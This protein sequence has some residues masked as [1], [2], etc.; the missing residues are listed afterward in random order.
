MNKQLVNAILYLSGLNCFILLSSTGQNIHQA[1]IFTEI[2][3]VPEGGRLEVTCSTFGFTEKAG[4][5]YLCKNGK[6]IDMKNRPTRQDTTFKIERIEMNHSG[7]YSC[8]FS[9]EQLQINKVMGYG[10]NSIFINVIGKV[11]HTF[12]YICECF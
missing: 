1:K 8:V 5:L 9:E 7:N 2:T 11:Y 10:H 6:A 4:Y 3:E 12:S